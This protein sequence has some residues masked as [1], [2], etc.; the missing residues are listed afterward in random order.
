MHSTKVMCTAVVALFCWIPLASAD[1]IQIRNGFWGGIDTGAGLVGLSYDQA[2]DED[3]VFWYLGFKGGYAL[4]PHFLIGIELGGWLLK[5]SDMNDPD[6]GKGISQ[7]FLITQ[8]YPRDESN[9]FLKAGAGHVSIWS[10]R[11]DDKRRR[12][13]LGVSVGAGYDFWLNETVTLSPFANFSYGDAGPWNYT[14]IT[15]GLG[16]TFP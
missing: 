10:N 16:I 12:Q 4:N 14:A 8:L 11:P 3:D 9:F 6:E 1:D 7:A 5:A 2:E 13:G 15:F